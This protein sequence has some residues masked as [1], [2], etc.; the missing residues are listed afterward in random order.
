MGRC[1]ILRAGI[2]LLE[3]N[4]AR[5]A[6]VATL[7]G[8]GKYFGSASGCCRRA[9]APAAHARGLIRRD[10]FYVGT[11]NTIPAFLSKHTIERQKYIYTSDFKMAQ[12]MDSII[13]F[14]ESSNVVNKG[15]TMKLDYSHLYT[16]IITLK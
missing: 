6:G 4:G 8:R 12:S 5:A 15:K 16:H 2:G 7:P 13:L 14:H 3:R 1:T 10:G 9:P 11:Q